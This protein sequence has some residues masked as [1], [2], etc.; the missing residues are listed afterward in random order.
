MAK[1]GR[2][3]G[4][5]T[6]PFKRA[7]MLELADAD[8]EYGKLRKIGAKLVEK[9]LDGDMAAIKEVADRTDGKP[10]QA[11][12]G[13]NGGPVQFMDLSNLTDEQ[14]DKS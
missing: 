9:A 11:I 13:P 12:T 8:G 2:P 5:K 7:L 3:K 6:N 14:L 1:V 4:S 10:S